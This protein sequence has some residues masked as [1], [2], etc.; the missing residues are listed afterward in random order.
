MKSSEGK[1]DEEISD[2]SFLADP[3]PR[4]K[5]VAN[6]IF[7]IVNKSRARRCGYTKGDDL[8]L[9]KYWGYMTKNNRG[10]QLKS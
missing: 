9:K 6:H 3:P 4:V 5:V 8:R 7:A 1:L 10:K 2:P